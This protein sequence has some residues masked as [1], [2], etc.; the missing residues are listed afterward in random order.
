[1]YKRQLLCKV[2][3]LDKPI[4]FL[5]ESKCW[6]AVWYIMNRWKET[7]WGTIIYLA[8]LSGISPCLL[9]TSLNSISHILQCLLKTLTKLVMQAIANTYRRFMMKPKRGKV[10]E[11]VV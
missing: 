10:Y 9:Y 5:T 1:M 4:D 3:I 8:A 11:T 6:R 7:G 2:G